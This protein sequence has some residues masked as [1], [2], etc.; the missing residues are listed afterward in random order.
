MVCLDEAEQ[1]AE[2]Q[3]ASVASPRVFTFG[4]ECSLWNAVQL[5]RN[6]QLV[7]GLESM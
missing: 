5:G 4:P 1:F 3:K 2:N 6:P 7:S